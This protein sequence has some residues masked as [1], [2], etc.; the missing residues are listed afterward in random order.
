MGASFIIRGN[1]LCWILRASVSR[2]TRL[3]D[4][5]L[6]GPLAMRRSTEV[7]PRDLQN[8]GTVGDGL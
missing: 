1:G 8:S 2:S 3:V 7:S 6:F 4:P 5:F